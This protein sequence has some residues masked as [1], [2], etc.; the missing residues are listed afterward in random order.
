MKAPPAVRGTLPVKHVTTFYLF[1]EYVQD[2]CIQ[3]AMLREFVLFSSCSY[4]HR[5][6]ALSALLFLFLAICSPLALCIDIDYAPPRSLLSCACACA[7][8]LCV[9]ARC[10]CVSPN[11]AHGVDFVS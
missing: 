11:L 9:H 6:C 7:C 2:L 10:P 4:V 1:F 3:V 8:A 5:P